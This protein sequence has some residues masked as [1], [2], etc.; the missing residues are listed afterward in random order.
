MNEVG[1]ADQLG[2]LRTRGKEGILE[3][4]F[5]GLELIQK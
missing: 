5:E 4:I 1:K 2:Q 3:N